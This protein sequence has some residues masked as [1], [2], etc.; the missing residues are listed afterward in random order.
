[1]QQNLYWEKLNGLA[2][3]E[4]TKRWSDGEVKEEVDLDSE[5]NGVKKAVMS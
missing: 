1:M 4:G 5:V 2:Y 3:T